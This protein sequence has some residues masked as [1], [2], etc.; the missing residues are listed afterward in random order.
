MRML[1]VVLVSFFAVA[2]AETTPPPAPKKAQP[3]VVHYRTLEKM[4]RR[5]SSMAGEPRTRG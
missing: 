2:H 5:F 3:T 4:L 1:A